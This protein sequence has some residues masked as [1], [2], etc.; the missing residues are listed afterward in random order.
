MTG[1]LAL[2]GGAE[3]GPGNEEQDRALA[4]A[5]AGRAAYVVCAAVRT[6]PEQAA[7]TASDGSPRS[8]SITFGERWIVSAQRALGEATPLLGVEERS[9]ALWRAGAWSAAGPGAVTVVI[10]DRRTRFASG[11]TI[12]GI[13]APAASMPE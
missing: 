10:G 5:A 9:A 4:D 1:P 13:P 12:A 7:A 6:H 11:E 2:A 3:F 8:A